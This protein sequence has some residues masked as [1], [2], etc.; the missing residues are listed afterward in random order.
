MLARVEKVEA[1]LAQTDHDA[2]LVTN[3]KNIYYLTDFSG[4]KR[5]FHQQ[6]SLEFF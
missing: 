6:E 4:P 5:R 3:L 1:A 2:G